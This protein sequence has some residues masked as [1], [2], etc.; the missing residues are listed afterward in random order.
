[1]DDYLEFSPTAEKAIQK[2]KDLTKLLSI[3]G[4][5]LTK[6]MSN[7]PNILQ[8]IEPNPDSQT[9]DGNPLLTT[10][11]SSHVLGLKWNHASDTLV[12]SF[13]EVISNKSSNVWSNKCLG[14]VRKM[15]LVQ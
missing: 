15:F 12:V 6:F 2:A 1:M 10:E 5:K 7:Y 3:G 8:H 13:Q 4:F 9:N 14:T 11:E